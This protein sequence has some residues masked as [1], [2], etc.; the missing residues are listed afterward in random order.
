MA[1]LF[2]LVA[3]FLIALGIIRWLKGRY[4]LASSARVSMAVMLLF[5][6]IGHFKFTEGMA[7]MIPEFIPYR[8]K[9]V[10]FTGIVEIAA[11]MGLLIPKFRRVTAWLLI[12]FFILILPANI[13][14]AVHQV[15]YQA[16][17]FS[18]PGL[19]YLWFRIPLQLLFIAWVYFSSI[20]P[21]GANKLI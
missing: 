19:Y 7:M 12:V 18:G 3:T 9:I 13:Y 11:A 15:D 5:T 16:E 14:A 21:Y 6:A 20:N 2:V 10:W 1:P 4:A 8:E 17:N